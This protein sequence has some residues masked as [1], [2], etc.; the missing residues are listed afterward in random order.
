LNQA[1]PLK[2]MYE[3]L[4][5]TGDISVANARLLDMLRQVGACAY[6]CMRVCV[7][8]YA[9]VRADSARTR[10]IERA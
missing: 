2:L 7:L 6:V 10:R 8:V 3:S 4:L 9:R 5:S 1:R